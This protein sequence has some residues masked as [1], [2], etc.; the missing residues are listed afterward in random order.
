MKFQV[1]GFISLSPHP[2]VYFSRWMHLPKSGSGWGFFL[3][4]GSV[5][6]PLLQSVCWWGIV[7]LLGFSRILEGLYRIKCIETTV[8]IR[9]YK[10]SPESNWREN[11]K[12]NLITTSEV[13]LLH[14]SYTTMVTVNKSGTHCTLGVTALLCCSFNIKDKHNLSNI[15]INGTKIKQ[16][17]APKCFSIKIFSN[18]S[19][20]TKVLVDKCKL[21]TH[22]YSEVILI[23]ADNLVY[24]T[25]NQH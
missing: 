22:K 1:G 23:G 18:T 15:L 12:Y 8:V 21:D 6:F 25:V 13:F 5:P 16:L 2:P 10:N 17:R 24:K 7:W 4:K 3:F 20:C 9:W 14:T 19:T 11:Q